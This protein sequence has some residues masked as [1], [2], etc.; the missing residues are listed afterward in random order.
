MNAPVFAL[1]ACGPPAALGLMYPWKKDGLYSSGAEPEHK[2]QLVL[3]PQSVRPAGAPRRFRALIL[4]CVG[5]TGEGRAGQ[6]QVSDAGSVSAKRH[7][8][9]CTWVEVW[10][11]LCL[12]VRPVGAVHGDFGV[13]AAGAAVPRRSGMA[14]AGVADVSVEVSAG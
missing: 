6:E 7:R 9:G 14:F 5:L 12:V 11:W 8:A 3:V 13:D 1:R 4:T 10:R 2:E